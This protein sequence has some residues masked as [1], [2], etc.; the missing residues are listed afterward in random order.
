MVMIYLNVPNVFRLPAAVR[1]P[2]PDRLCL[3]F[4]HPTDQIRVQ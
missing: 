3:C 4:D 1:D 2:D